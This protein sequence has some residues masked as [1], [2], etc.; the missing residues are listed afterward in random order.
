MSPPKETAFATSN[1]HQITDLLDDSA[2]GC[3]LHIMKCWNISTKYQLNHKI[4]NLIVCQSIISTNRCRLHIQA[5]TWLKS[6]EYM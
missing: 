4:L 5:I 2:H 3:T 6:Y 1:Q